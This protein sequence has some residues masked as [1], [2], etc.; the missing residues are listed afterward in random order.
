MEIIE[1][2]G[3][4]KFSYALQGAGKHCRA[5]VAQKNHR[6]GRELKRF[7]ADYM[8]EQ[9]LSLIFIRWIHSVFLLVTVFEAHACT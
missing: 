3:T 9:G 5:V 8:K 2:G 6:D 4:L 7:Q 1:R